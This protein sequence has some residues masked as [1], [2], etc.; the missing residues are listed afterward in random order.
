LQKNDF[1]SLNPKLLPKGIQQE[2]LSI[3][4]DAFKDSG[5]YLSL[6]D[7]AKITDLS[8]VTVKRYI[9]FLEESGFIKEEIYYQQRGRPLRKYILLHNY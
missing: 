4:V 5:Y 6:F 8:R 3:I 7:I 1:V 2:T 9:N